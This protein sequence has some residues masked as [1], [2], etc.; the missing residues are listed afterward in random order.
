MKKRLWV[1]GWVLAASLFGLFSVGCMKKP[2]ASVPAPEPIRTAP[3]SHREVIYFLKGDASLFPGAQAKLRTWTETWGT[4]GSWT[5][6]CP[7]GPDITYG[8][9]ESRILTLRGELQKLG[10]TQVATKLTLKEQPK[11]YDPVFIEL[12]PTKGRGVTERFRPPWQLR[13]SLSYA[14]KVSLQSAKQG[15]PPARAKPHTLPTKPALL[16]K[17]A[18]VKLPPLR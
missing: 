11:S 3:M 16:P 1:S 9:L 4:Q 10:A 15:S 6:A 5:L 12:D 8:L 14:K 13:P 7:P 2:Q 18:Q 17:V